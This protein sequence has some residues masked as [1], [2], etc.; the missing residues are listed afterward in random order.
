M[1]IMSGVPIGF[2]CLTRHSGLS[3]PNDEN[4][5]CFVIFLNCVHYNP[6]EA[7]YYVWAK[8]LKAVLNAFDWDT[9]LSFI[10]QFSNLDCIAVRCDLYQGLIE[11]AICWKESLGSILDIIWPRD[12]VLYY[13]D[14]ETSG[15]W[16]KI[17]YEALLERIDE[18][19]CTQTLLSS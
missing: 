14:D 1:S 6:S 9:L 10:L 7:S 11:L 3:D 8:D 17:G 19:V 15:I 5:Q 18:L 4:V 2:S 16:H 12:L 13:E